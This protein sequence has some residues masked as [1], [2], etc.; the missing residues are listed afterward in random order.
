VWKYY[1]GMEIYEYT[2]ATGALRNLTKSEGYD[3][4][5]S[6]SPDGKLIVFSSFRDGQQKIYIC[7]ADGG[8]ARRI[9][10][11]PGDGGPFFSPDGQ[12][13]IYRGDR[14]GNGNMQVYTNNLEGTDEKQLT[15]EDGASH[16]CPY[17]HP[18]GKWIAY[19]LIQSRGGPPRFDVYVM[20]A[21][22]SDVRR[23]TS[24]GEWNGL[25]VFSPDGKRLAWTSKRD[26]AD[27]P[28]IFVADF[29]GITPEGE[30]RADQ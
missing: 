26:K 9:S 30:L 21:D 2:F 24:Q 28:Q 3:A 14:A 13:V 1:P 8:N 18:S 23:V 5:A 17:F 10:N 15:K 16:W 6:Y 25:P 27:T 12:R 11:G 4:E 22:G 29:V 7:D 19:T 20:R